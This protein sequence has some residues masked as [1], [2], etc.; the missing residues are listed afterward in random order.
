[1]KQLIILACTI[2][3]GTQSEIKA[4]ARLAEFSGI[5]NKTFSQELQDET[6]TIIK[7]IIIP[8]MAADQQSQ[9]KVECIY[10]KDSFLIDKIKPYSI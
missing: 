2:P 7:W 8:I 9:I 6:N 10:P 5:M 4:R 1:M 3:F